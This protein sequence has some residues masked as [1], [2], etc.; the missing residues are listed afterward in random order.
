MY[1]SLLSQIC[2][3]LNARLSNKYYANVSAEIGRTNNGGEL[4]RVLAIPSFFAS[5]ISLASHLFGAVIIAFPLYVFAKQ[6]KGI[7]A[8]DIGLVAVCGLVVG[9]ESI[10]FGVFFGMIAA[11]IAGLIIRAA[12]GGSRIALAPWLSLGIAAA[13]LF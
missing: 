3:S 10:I 4:L 6:R 13:I 7:G 8:G 1:N 9:M 11:V 2:T 5:S 12:A